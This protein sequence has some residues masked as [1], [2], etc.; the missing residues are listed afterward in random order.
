MF[1]VSKHPELL[2]KMEKFLKPGQTG[3]LQLSEKR[4]TH[5][6]LIVPLTLAGKHLAE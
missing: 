6:V 5:G 1:D 4:S 2:G 3:A